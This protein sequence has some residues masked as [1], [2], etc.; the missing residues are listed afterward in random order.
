M[1]LKRQSV[2]GLRIGM[3]S[4]LMIEPRLSPA[5]AFQL[6]RAIGIQATSHEEKG[7]LEDHAIAP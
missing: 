2:L 7:L 5:K 3:K 4:K 1:C 6:R